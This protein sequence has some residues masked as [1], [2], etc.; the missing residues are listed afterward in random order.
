VIRCVRA[1]QELAA[2]GVSVEVIDLRTLVPL[3]EEAIY[4]S[5]R[6]TGKVIVVH[7]APLT[8]GFGGE[9]AARIAE[10]CFEHL[11]APVRRLAARDSFVAYAPGLEAAILPSQEDVTGAIRELARL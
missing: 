3:D 5:V 4:A 10:H 9:I 8:G 11:D 1:A 7:E 2:L 6:K